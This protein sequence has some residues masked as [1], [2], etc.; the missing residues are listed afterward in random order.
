MRKIKNLVRRLIG[1]NNETDYYS[2][3]GEDAILSNIFNYVLPT[4]RGFYVDV[5]AYHPFKHSN[6]YLLYRAGW[7]G[8]N[9]DPR[10]GS[11]ALFDKHRPG[12]TNLELGV[13]AE[14]GKMTYYMIDEGSTMNSFSK[15]NLEALEMF[16]KV[17]EKIEIPVRK[18]SSILT[19][20]REQA[21]V[22]YLNIDAEGYELEILG[23]LT[24]SAIKPSV[25]SVEQN[26]PLTLS[27][28][29]ASETEA[30]FLSLAIHRS[31]RI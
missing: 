5:G 7:R 12:D 3:A 23:E 15:E 1:L 30:F 13:A 18:L 17:T 31:Q 14:E 6:T 8:I 10:P 9:I 2:Q 19:E 16:D 4:D 24:N 25:V 27:D 29:L 28:V 20:Y 22:D 11:K 26:G 21:E